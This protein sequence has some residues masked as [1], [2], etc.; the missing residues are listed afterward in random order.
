MKIWLAALVA[1]LSRLFSSGLGRWLTTALLW[2]G[3]GLATKEG[4]IDPFLTYL[5]QG[6]SGLPSIAAQWIGF[7]NI[8]VYAS[9]VFSAYVAAAVKRVVLR[10]VLA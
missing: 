6:F 4:V 9:A 8:D 1:A 3:I 5:Q 10:K 7:F 2:M